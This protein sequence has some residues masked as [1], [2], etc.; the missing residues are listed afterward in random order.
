[1]YRST[2]KYRTPNIRMLYNRHKGSIA[3]KY[4]V[5]LS[6]SIGTTSCTFIGSGIEKNSVEALDVKSHTTEGPIWC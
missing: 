2:A 1:M 4:N 6:V 3:S 5:S